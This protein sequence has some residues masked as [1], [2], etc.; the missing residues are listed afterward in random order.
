[1]RFDAT[2]LLALIL[3]QRSVARIQT[4]LNSCDRSQRQKSVAATMIF[5]CH[6]MRSVAATCRGDVSQRFVASCVS[7]LRPR[8]TMR[9]IAAI[10]RCDTSPRLYCCCD[11]ALSL[12]LSLRYVARI[13]TSLNSC[14]RSQRQNSVAATMVFTCHTRRFVAAICRGDVSQ[15]FVASCVSALK[16]AR[17]LSSPSRCF[18]ILTKIFFFDI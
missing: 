12:S 17:A 15:R 9:Q 10:R 4:S 6:T 18:Q 1:M 14:D 3:S 8:H 7:A 5:T 13:Q 16:G 2:R 11:K